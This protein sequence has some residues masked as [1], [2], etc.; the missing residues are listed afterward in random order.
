MLYT[1]GEKV[2]HSGIYTVTHDPGHA[3]AH[4]V[5]CIKGRKFPIF[6]D[7]AYKLSGVHFAIFTA[8]F[9]LRRLH[10]ESLAQHLRSPATHRS[11]D[12]R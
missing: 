8:G 11:P 2:P 1:P 3:R 4:E 9:W 5:T 10:A 6:V 12:A 7:V